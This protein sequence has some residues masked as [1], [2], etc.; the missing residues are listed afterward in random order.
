MAFCAFYDSDYKFISV[1]QPGGAADGTRT[2]TIPANQIPENTVYIRCSGLRTVTDNYVIPFDLYNVLVN[3]ST[4]ADI[5]AVISQ[6]N[7]YLMVVT[8]IVVGLFRQRF[9]CP[10]KR[11]YSI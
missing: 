6:I 11:I 3:L 5:N 7:T 9:R 8:Y 2:A 1:W 4:K 10:V